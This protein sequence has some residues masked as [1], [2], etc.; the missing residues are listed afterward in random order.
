MPG[1]MKNGS[2]HPRTQKKAYG[3]GATLTAA[4]WL[5]AMAIFPALPPPVHVRSKALPWSLIP[6]R[7][8]PVVIGAF[9]AFP[10]TVI[11]PEPE[12]RGV[13]DEEHDVHGIAFRVRKAE[14]AEY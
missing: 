2:P 12:P 3:S 11:A 6:S 10:E 13:N 14:E 1:S 4:P 5:L 9:H 8:R 7:I